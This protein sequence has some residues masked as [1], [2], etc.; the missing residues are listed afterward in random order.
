LKRFYVVRGE[1]GEPRELAVERDGRRITVS[2]AGSSERMDAS[3]LPDGRMS[4][5]FED[6][7]QFSGRA[8]PQGDG[9]ELVDAQGRRRIAIADPL[10]DRVLHS[11]PGGGA[12]DSGAEIHAQMPGRVVEIKVAAGDRVE[13]GSVLL[14]LEAMKMQNEIRSERAG[15]VERVDVQPGQPVEGGALLAVVRAE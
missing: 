5:V 7:R 4:L 10:R 1:D 6:G 13:S 15:V 8:L 9:V 2:F 14:V 11:A 12:A 3:V